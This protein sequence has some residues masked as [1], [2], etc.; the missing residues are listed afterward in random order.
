MPV[1]KKSLDN[2]GKGRKF[3][4]GNQ[5]DNRGRRRSVLTTI[6]EGGMSVTDIKKVIMNLIWEYDSKE[7]AE[8]LKDKEQMIPMGMTLILGAL[9]DDQKK[10]SIANFEK[11]M[12]RA[13]GKPTQ[14]SVV[15]FTD[16]PDNAKDRLKQI[17]STAQGKTAEAKPRKATPKTA[18]RKKGK[19]EAGG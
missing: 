1:A 8:L 17:F 9:A 2:L 11:L 5:P 3:S 14:N 16:I 10:H 18:A 13:A 12:D 4:S 7:L 6:R 15:E 19:D